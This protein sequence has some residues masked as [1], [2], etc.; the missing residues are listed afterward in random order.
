MKLVVN[1]VLGLN[2]AVLAEGLS[3]A[4]ACGM[5]L[6]Q[7]LEVLQATPAY[8]AIMDP[9]GVKMIEQDFAP[10]ARLAQ[11]LKDVGLIRKLAREHGALVPLSNLHEELLRRAVEM[12]L[13][14][15]DNCAIIK[16][17]EQGA[18]S[19]RSALDANFATSLHSDGKEPGG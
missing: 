11:H 15:L 18:R 6:T 7:T 8:S 5:D 1:L 17:F 2:R 12:G 14:E 10:Q 16:V 3:L 13:G 9:K 19:G 4:K